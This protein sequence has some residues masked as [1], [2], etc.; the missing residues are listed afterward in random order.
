MQSQKIL[1]D[2]Y[3]YVSFRGNQQAIVEHVIAGGD[4]LFLMPTDTGFYYNIFMV[5]F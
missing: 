2:V 4:A 5:N 1:Q 3:G